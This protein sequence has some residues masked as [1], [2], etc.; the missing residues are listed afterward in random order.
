MSYF[1][2]VEK[3][4]SL[5]QTLSIMLYFTFIVLIVFVI[6]VLFT[7]NHT[8]NSAHN[9]KLKI[10]E[11]EKTIV[12]LTYKLENQS[13]KIKLMEDLKLNIKQSNQILGEQI[14]DLNHETFSILFSKKNNI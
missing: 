13:Q 2:S 12:D 1:K 11:L 10:K 4:K 5:H 3:K 7:L 9:F 14:L 8:R 6:A